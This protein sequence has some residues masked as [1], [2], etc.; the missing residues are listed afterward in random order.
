MVVPAVLG[1]VV[2]DLILFLLGLQRLALGIRG[3]TQAVVE[4][5]NL[6]KHRRRRV[7]LV[8]AVMALR[9]PIM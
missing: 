5:D 8:V 1:L 9:D 7:V 3:I 6:S 4:E 2:L